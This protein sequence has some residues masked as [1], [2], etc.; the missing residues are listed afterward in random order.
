MKVNDH[1]LDCCRYLVHHVMDAELPESKSDTW[2]KAFFN[3][4][5]KNS[6]NSWMST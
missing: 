4:R 3:A 1:A 2:G 6:K 5:K